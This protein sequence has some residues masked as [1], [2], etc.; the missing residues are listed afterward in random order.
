MGLNGVHGRSRRYSTL[1]LTKLAR[2]SSKDANPVSA[3]P[4]PEVYGQNQDYSQPHTDTHGHHDAPQ[5]PS[6]GHCKCCT[7]C[8]AAFSAVHPLLVTVLCPVTAGGQGPWHKDASGAPPIV[9]GRA[10]GAGIASVPS[11]ALAVACGACGAEARTAPC[12]RLHKASTRAHMRTCCESVTC[13]HPHKNT[14][15]ALD[16]RNIDRS[17]S[18][19]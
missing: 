18:V 11:P 1:K 6:A 8:A 13:T 3:A 2:T 4:P 14:C 7:R 9:L 10:L 15:P 17:R 16:K 19:C 12:T 5:A